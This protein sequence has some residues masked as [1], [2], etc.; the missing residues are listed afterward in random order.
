MPTFNRWWWWWWWKSNK[1][2][3][4]NQNWK[5]KGHWHHHSR[6]CLYPMTMIIINNNNHIFIIAFNKTTEKN[7]AYFEEEN[8]HF[9]RFLWARFCFVPIFWFMRR[10][11]F[12][13]IFFL[14]KTWKTFITKMDENAIICGH[15]GYFH[16]T[17]TKR[18]ESMLESKSNDNGFVGNRKNHCVS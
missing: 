4:E 14:W 7:M 8:I 2:K 3:T 12:I 16:E 13:I 10:L 15:Y 18:I 1:P 17:E 5:Q 6:R 11:F 9:F